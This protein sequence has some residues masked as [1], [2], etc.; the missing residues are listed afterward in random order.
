MQERWPYRRKDI[1]MLEKIQRRA[2]K[3]ISRYEERILRG[4]HV[5]VF[6]IL[7]GHA[8]IDPI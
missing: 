6:I 4:S 8:N 7:N 2:T 5:D 3:P 1:D